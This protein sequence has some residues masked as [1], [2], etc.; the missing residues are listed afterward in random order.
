MA[1][2]VRSVE[3]RAMTNGETKP[4]RALLLLWC[5]TRATTKR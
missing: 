3:T 4:R 1:H 2:L 5:D